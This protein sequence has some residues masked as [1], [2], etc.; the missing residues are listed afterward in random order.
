MTIDK[1]QGKCFDLSRQHRI[2]RDVDSNM[3]EDIDEVETRQNFDQV[4][5]ENVENTYNNVSLDQEKVKTS[6]K[7]QKLIKE[8]T[9]N[10]YDESG[11]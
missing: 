11:N 7:F 6:P 1:T 4:S 8:E 2:P 9:T 5:E 10:S 3:V